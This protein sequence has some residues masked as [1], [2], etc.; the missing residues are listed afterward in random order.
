MAVGPSWP[1]IVENMQIFPFAGFSWCSVIIYTK[2]VLDSSSSLELN[3][4]SGRGH[5]GS[6]FTNEEQKKA[7][8]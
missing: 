1:E 5:V 7:G 2:E 4:S 8:C 6:L 3:S